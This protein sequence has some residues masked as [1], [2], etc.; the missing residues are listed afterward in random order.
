MWE[1]LGDFHLGA[2]RAISFDTYQVHEEYVPKE[3][4]ANDD[5]YVQGNEILDARPQHVGNGR[6]RYMPQTSATAQS[7]HT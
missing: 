7:R 1:Q 3:V 5:E 6:Q 2:A 4:Q